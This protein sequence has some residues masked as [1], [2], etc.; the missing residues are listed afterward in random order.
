MQARHTLPQ[1]VRELLGHQLEATLHIARIDR[2]EIR[3]WGEPVHIQAL[4]GT[5]SATPDGRGDDS[6]ATGAVS[7]LDRRQALDT[8]LEA[9]AAGLERVLAGHD[10]RLT[11]EER[12]GLEAVLVL[13]ARPPIVADGNRLIGAAP[14]WP[15]LEEQRAHIE[16]ALRGIGR[17]ELLGHPEL[18][19]AGTAF[20]VA[21]HCLVTT[22]VVAQ[23]FADS[24]HSPWVFRP[25]TSAWMDFGI[26]SERA[27]DARHRVVGVL[28]VLDDCDLALLEI[29]PVPP[30]PGG[31]APLI[32]AGAAPDDV[33]GRAVYLVGHPVRDSRRD[34]PSSFANLFAAGFG[35]KRVTPGRLTGLTDR[36]ELTHDAALVGR[37]LGGCLLDLETHQ[38]LGVHAA[39]RFPADGVA[40][41]LW[42]LRDDPL[43]ARA[44]VTFAEATP[45]ELRVT[46]ARVERLSRSPYWSDLQAAV[47]NFYRRADD[48]SSPPPFP[49]HERGPGA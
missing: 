24:R 42:S 44:G 6:A 2:Q 25:G 41:P 21:E 32:V 19:W 47:D 31:P 11:C 23:A 27:A 9:G 30:S 20:L 26:S 49:P 35:S 39:A 17:V 45:G 22:R 12:A 43:L 33:V 8:L 38:V 1:R 36:Q 34:E 15:E 7:T 40:V 5:K 4:L 18:D 16:S 37:W 10:E 46:Q 13:Y 28:G 48:D 14:L 3:G 29:E